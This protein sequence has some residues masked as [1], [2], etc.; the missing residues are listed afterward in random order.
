MSD[1]LVVEDE[2]VLA[3]SIVGFLER[4]GFSARFALD[5]V[6]AR[7][8]F[9]EHPPRLVLLDYKLNEDDGLELLEWLR[10][11]DER[12]QVVMMTGHGDVNV[13]VRAMKAGARDFL[14]KPTP[15][16]SIA[17]IAAELMLSEMGQSLDPTGAERIIGRSSVANRLRKQ[18]RQLARARADVGPRPG[19]LI[20]GP[21]GSGKSLVATA[22]HETASGPDAPLVVIDCSTMESGGA[23]S[24]LSDAVRDAAGGTLVLRDVGQIDPVG[25]A[26]LLRLLDRV[27]NP[28]SLIATSETHLAG[29]EVFLPA[30]LFRLQVG[31]IDVPPLSERTADILPVA[32]FHA[33]R[34]ARAQA[35]SRPRFSPLARARLLEHDWPGNLAELVNCVERAMLMRDGEV[36]EGAHIRPVSDVAAPEGDRMPTLIELELTAI[37]TAL[38]RTGGNV[39]RAAEMLGVSRDTLRYRMEKFDLQRK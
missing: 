1:I 20:I 17:A 37:R 25:Q 19:V 23:T 24:Q 32:E 29:G 2:T 26:S 39:S 30:L 15:L 21:A 8:M 14:T 11:T 9:E 31:W 13:A 10:A 18:I 28:P 6:S 7:T 33:R 5:A 27:E 35:G 12:A 4:R 16:A 36:I 34:L 3:R 22:L 38:R